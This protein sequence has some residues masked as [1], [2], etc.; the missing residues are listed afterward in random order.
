LARY[1]IMELQR[2]FALSVACIVAAVGS[3]FADRLVPRRAS[4]AH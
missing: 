2:I 3:L 1:R 4:R